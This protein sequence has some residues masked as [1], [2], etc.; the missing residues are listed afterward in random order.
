MSKPVAR[1]GDPDLVHCSQPIRAE[2]S[3]NVF[4]NGRGWSR[5]GD[6]N[7]PHLKPSG[8]ECVSHAAPLAKGSSPVFVNGSGGGRVTDSIMGCT[9]VAS[10]S[11]NVFCG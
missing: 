10:G 4:V 7:A 11:P 5:M 9:A 1:K 3:P 2:C 8:D 6:H